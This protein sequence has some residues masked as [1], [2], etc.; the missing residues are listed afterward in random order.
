MT[1]GEYLRSIRKIRN[2]RMVKLAEL[3]GISPSY[4]SSME[5]GSRSAPSFE[6]LRKMADLLEMNTSERYCLY[7]LAA[8]TKTPRT[9]SDDLNE[10]IYRIPHLRDVLRSSMECGL[11]EKEWNKIEEFIK[12]NYL[13]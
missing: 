8:E 13:I 4:L 3:L 7:D 9:L 12:K 1:F 2:I 11:T 10:Y 5:S 6:T